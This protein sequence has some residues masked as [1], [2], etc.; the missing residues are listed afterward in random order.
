MSH[1]YGACWG[2]VARVDRIPHHRGVSCGGGDRRNGGRLQK[3]VS[4][5]KKQTFQICY[6]DRKVTATQ[7]LPSAKDEAAQDND[8]SSENAKP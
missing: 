1:H 3:H 4:L 5:E 8:K 7:A 6:R 2:N